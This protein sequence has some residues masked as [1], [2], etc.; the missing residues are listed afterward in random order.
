MGAASHRL[1]LASVAFL[2]AGIVFTGFT[3]AVAATD[4]LITNARLIDGTGAPPRENLSI[5][6]RGGRILTVGP[7]VQAAG[8][9]VLDVA[10]ATVLPG[11]IDAH[12]HMS[13]APG[14]SF[15][16]DLP[17]TITALR[18]R[19][20][21]G[22]LASGVTTVA[23]TG[24]SPEAIHSIREMMASGVP[25]PRFLAMGWALVPAGGWDSPGE[26]AAVAGESDV[27]AR[28][29]E[30]VRLGGVGVKVALERG[31]G[32]I[33]TYELL[34]PEIRRAIADGAARRGLPVFIHATN[35]PDQ[36]AA[37]Q[38]KPRALTHTV[39]DLT[40]LTSGDLLSPEFVRDMAAS[41]TYQITTLSIVDAYLVEFE[42]SRLDD[43][44][45]N[46]VVPEVELQT[47]RDPRV[48]RAQA[49]ALIHMGAPW[50]PSIFEACVARMTFRKSAVRR[51]LRRAQ[52]SVKQLFEAGV[53]IV[54]GSDTPSLPQF[55]VGAYQFHGFSTIREMELLG[56]AGLPP[57]TIV[58]SATRI[59]AE[60]LGIA[61]DVGT[62]EIGKRADLVIL[63]ADPLVDLRA[64]KTVLW[65][66]RDGVART[67]EEWIGKKEVKP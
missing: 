60:M 5:L 44:F 63:R 40:G 61:N 37:L 12:V 54:V 49:R 23:D 52:W 43:A 10:G 1:G 62:V 53:P 41:G 25:G 31:W 14:Q 39:I 4:L 33:K 8:L 35:P 11:L 55:A 38:M 58:Q 51:A 24:A 18:A 66:V 27:E 56:E 16:R 57:M 21:R 67:P 6:I 47:A 50:L 13:W 29:D 2:A 17:E 9:P 36:V 64:L 45:L 26:T 42:P 30:V 22:Y 3:P 65:T 28:L 34:S 7:D 20:L 46:L 48:G 59:P 19:H 15:R 32:P